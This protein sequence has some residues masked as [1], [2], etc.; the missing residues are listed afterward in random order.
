MGGPLVF[1][2]LCGKMALMLFSCALYRCDGIPMRGINPKIKHKY[3]T[4]V[5]VDSGNFP[6]I[7]VLDG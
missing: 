1:V 4:E 6:K 5:V 2:A 3:A 7:N